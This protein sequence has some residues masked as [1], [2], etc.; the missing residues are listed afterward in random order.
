[1]VIVAAFQLGGRERWVIDPRRFAGSPRLKIT[2]SEQVTRVELTGARYPGTDLPADM[3]VKSDP[4]SSARDADQD[5]AR[6]LKGDVPFEQWLA[7]DAHMISR[8]R[9]SNS[10]CDLGTNSQALLHGTGEAELS[11][12]WTLRINGRE[13][14]GRKA[15]R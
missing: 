5:G 9:F 10:V 11:P 14:T 4:A 13:I 1:V 3:S 6:R 8:V 12:D 2:E 7:G 15:Q